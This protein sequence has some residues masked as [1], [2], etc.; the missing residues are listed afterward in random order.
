MQKRIS[1]NT[2]RYAFDSMADM[3]RFIANEPKRWRQ[4]SSAD[5]SHSKSWDLGVTYKQAC[6][7]ARNGWIDGAAKA[8]QALKVFTPATPAP[9]MRNDFYGHAPNVPRYCAG[10]PD[11]M[12]RHSP[13]PNTGTGRVLTFIVAINA[14][15]GTDAQCMANYGLA[16]AQYVNQL[17]AEGTRVE[18]IASCTEGAVHGSKTGNQLTISVT[19]KRADQPLDLAVIS[20]AIGHPTMFRRLMFAAMERTECPEM[21]AYGYPQDT[22][23]GE[24]I[25]APAGAAI[26]NGMRQANT[27]AKTPEAALAHIT[28]EIDKAIEERFAK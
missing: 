10:A 25:N 28:A 3:E 18:V 15:S 5:P 21:E 4:N 2:Y 1:G 13:N 26:L 27:H 20:Y 24:V 6:D 7:M 11:N 9:Q 14:S 12:L 8:S 17:E 16:I 22:A 19:I 23:D